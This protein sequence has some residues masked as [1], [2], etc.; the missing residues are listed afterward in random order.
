M[1]EKIHFCDYEKGF[2]FSNEGEFILW[3]MKDAWNKGISPADFRKNSIKDLKTI[4]DIG[5]A[6][7]LREYRER[8]KQEMSNNLG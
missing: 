1:I 5:Q 3:M 8:K 2:K 6:I 7:S 4:H